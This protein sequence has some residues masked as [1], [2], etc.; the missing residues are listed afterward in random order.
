MPAPRL[1]VAELD[2]IPYRC[3]DEDVAP[4]RFGHD[5]CRH[6]H[7]LSVQLRDALTDL[8]DMDADA[9]PDLA[10][11]V[12]GV[13]LLQPALDVDGAVDC[14]GRGWEEHQETVAE[15][16][17]LLALMPSEPVPDHRRLA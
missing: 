14:S 5:P 1:A 11:G 15:E 9:D 12:D 7:G 3:G 16:L 4:R 13:V 17:S 2:L 6:V 8:A 10:L